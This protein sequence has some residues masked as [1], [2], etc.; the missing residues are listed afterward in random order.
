M[1][2]SDRCYTFVLLKNKN[3]YMKV[4]IIE[5][6]EAKIE[7][8]YK[9]TSIVH[10]RNSV[11]MAD[12]L[13]ADLISVESEI[14]SVL[15]RKYDVIICMYASGYMM[16]NKYVNIL[17][18]NTQARVFWLV[19]DHTVPD[20]IVLRK[21][22]EKCGISYDMICNN[23]RE[24]YKQSHLNLMIRNKKL[25]EWIQNWY[26]VNLNCLVYDDSF[27]RKIDENLFDNSKADC[28]YYGTYR[29]DRIKDMID[30]N[31][32]NYGISTSKK[33][34]YKFKK[35]GVSSRFGDK[36]SWDKG[37]ETLFT[38]KYSIYF[39]D[40]HT[41]TNYAFMANRFY[42]CLMLDVL[43]FYD[44]RCNMVIEKSGY[45]IDNFMIVKNGDEL[46]EKINYINS[47][48]SFYTKLI[49]RQRAN[50]NIV[51]KEKE[52]VL[53]SIEQILLLEKPEQQKLEEFIKERK[54]KKDDKNTQLDIFKTIN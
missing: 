45:E 49:E 51:K 42:E 47:N 23:A 29:K 50:C 22:V 12:Y 26:V 37:R 3:K 34:V 17:L 6:C 16:Y 2:L 46:N 19:N 44:Y 15:N 52:C 35:D 38:Y 40:E 43:L 53:K 13:D 24:S 25:N 14:E 39:E 21:Y 48:E 33:N 31:S 18:N 5:S 7:R 30:Y 4:L 9:R 10:V 41:H 54:E 1:F 27:V 11:V 28:I 32:A 36:L 8:N 20:N